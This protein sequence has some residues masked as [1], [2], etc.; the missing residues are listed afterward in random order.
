MKFT[1]AAAL[2]V[3]VESAQVDWAQKGQAE[4]TKMLVDFTD[5]EKAA[6]NEYQMTQ[7]F[8]ETW[9]PALQCLGKKTHKSKRPVECSEKEQAAFD[10]VKEAIES[11]GKETGD[12]SK[13]AVDPKVLHAF[14]SLAAKTAMSQGMKVSDTAIEKAALKFIKK[15]AEMATEE[16]PTAT[17]DLKKWS[18]VLL[19][20]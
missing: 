1:F 14:K 15:A 12:K 6:F 17:G 4:F 9:V 16:K 20:S 11:A 13:A 7:G 2:A 8:Y 19:L 5:A 10:A 18:N 3:A